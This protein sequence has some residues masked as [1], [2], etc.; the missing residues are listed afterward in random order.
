M[1]KAKRAGNK[2]DLRPLIDIHINYILNKEHRLA[3]GTLA[4]MRPQPN[5]IWLDDLFMAIPALAVLRV[6]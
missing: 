4:R 2:T 3:D 5:T 6:S 1:I